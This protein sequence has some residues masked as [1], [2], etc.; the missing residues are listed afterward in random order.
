MQFIKTI[1]SIIISAGILMAC[2][3]NNG[4]NP[5]AANGASNTPGISGSGD[6]YYYEST[7][8][9]S[10][11]NMTIDEVIK[12]FVSSKGDIRMESDIHNSMAG[13]KPSAP[14]IMLSHADTP[15]ESID[16]DDSAKTYT[17]NHFD[18]ASIGNDEMKINST[19]TKVGNEII[20]G[21]SCVHAKIISHKTMGSFY[22]ATDTIDL[23]KSNDVPQ[24]ALVKNK[25]DKLESGKGNSMYSTETAA[26]LKDMGC[27]GFTVKMIMNGDKSSMTMKLTKVER[28]NFPA[29]MFAIPAG[30]KEVKE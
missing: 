28:K 21:F 30:Y 20:M 29:S 3:S 25:M 17:I 6:D 26:Q 22:N 14:I 9:S 15:A 23:W 4:G 1:G 7:M 18:T 13:N 24:Q 27:V 8:N 12:M 16:L 11:K 5:S 10:G 2:N 19:A